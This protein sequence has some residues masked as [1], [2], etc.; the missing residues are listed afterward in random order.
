MLKFAQIGFGGLGKVHYNNIDVIK[1]N[2]G[3]IEL[4]ALC[5][6][7]ESQFTRQTETNLGKN[8]IS[9]DFSKIHIYTDY[10]EMIEKEE[11]DFVITALPTYLHA[12][13]AIYAMDKGIHVFSE[14][15]MAL[16]LEDCQAMIDASKRN[17]V[18]LMIGQCLRFCPYW[19]KVK[20]FI[21]SGKYGKVVKA[22]FS[23]V[24]ARPMD[25]WED[26]MDDVEKSGGCILDMHVHDTD[27]I[28]F[29][30]GKPKAVST[31]ATHEKTAY[32]GVNTNYIFDDKVC[33]ANGDWGYADTYRFSGAYRIRFE[34]AT[35]SIWDGPVKVFPDEGEPYEIKI[36]GNT[37]YQNEIIEF[38]NCIREDRVCEQ[39]TPESSMQTIEI[40]LK[41]KESADTNQIVML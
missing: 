31:V 38:I 28:N 26:W 23:R 34:K 9:L 35:L 24:S 40:V 1:E 30:F 13:V 16:N 18:K 33:V 6:V 12:E 19:L 14:K 5:D 4:V 41:E 15:P 7:D 17:N 21:D 27:F 37:S 3:D 22:E 10:K 25:K 20:E 36:E 2:V 39:N 29:L 11:L 32:D 8:D